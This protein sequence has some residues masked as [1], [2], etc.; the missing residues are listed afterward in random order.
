MASA[1]MSMSTRI[2]P[3]ESDYLHHLFT[4]QL[5][6]PLALDLLLLHHIHVPFAEIVNEILV[7]EIN[8]NTIP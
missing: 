3:G 4:V 7:T 8:W 5:P 6:A 1:I 2:Q